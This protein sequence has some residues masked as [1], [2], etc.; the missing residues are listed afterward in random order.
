MLDVTDE[1]SPD[2]TSE[3]TDEDEELSEDEELPDVFG[4]EL[5]VELMLVL[6]F[7]T[8]FCV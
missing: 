6:I 7:S 1:A 2:E 4:T 8:E 3:L 5:L